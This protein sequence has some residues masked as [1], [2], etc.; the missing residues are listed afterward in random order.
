MPRSDGE[1]K[2]NRDE[3]LQ[4]V[5]VSY[6]LWNMV[7][8]TSWSYC[9]LRVGWAIGEEGVKEKVDRKSRV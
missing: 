4:E 6:N 5:L 1:K 8:W 9:C 7:G 2:A 3:I